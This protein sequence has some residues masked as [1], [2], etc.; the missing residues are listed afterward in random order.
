[1]KKV[2]MVLVLSIVALNVQAFGKKLAEPPRFECVSRS[3][4]EVITVQKWGGCP[5][6]FKRL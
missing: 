5:T 3:T 4:G 6:G 2:L 1:M